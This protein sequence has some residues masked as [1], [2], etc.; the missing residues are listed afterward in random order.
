MLFLRCDIE[1]PSFES[2]PKDYMSTPS[3]KFGSSSTVSDK[4][5]EKIAKMGVKF[6]G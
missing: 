2:Q 4:F 5:I 1:N 6:G 3:N